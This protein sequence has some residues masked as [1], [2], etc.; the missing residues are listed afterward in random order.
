MRHHVT[1]VAWKRHG[2][3]HGLMRE[4]AGDIVHDPWLTKKGGWLKLEV[5]AELPCKC[6]RHRTIDTYRHIKTIIHTTDTDSIAKLE[7]RIEHRIETG[8][9]TGCVGIGH[10]HGYGIGF[11]I[12]LPSEYLWKPLPLSLGG[13]EPHIATGGNTNTLL[14]KGKSAL[15]TFGIN[16]I[17][18]HSL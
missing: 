1:A 14:H 12:D 17:E 2:R 4:E 8:S 9:M 15:M 5:E 16:V 6:G 7:I 18:N 3:T 13:L 10:T 11:T